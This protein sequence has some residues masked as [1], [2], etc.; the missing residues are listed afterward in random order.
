MC[1]SREELWEMFE[2]N[3][4]EAFDYLGDDRVRRS[5]SFTKRR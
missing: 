3:Q 4:K 2:I 5:A 1:M